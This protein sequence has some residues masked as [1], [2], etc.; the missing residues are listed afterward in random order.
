VL[1]G[2]LSQGDGQRGGPDNLLF[3]VSCSPS[4]CGCPMPA[5]DAVPRALSA[6]LRLT[7]AP[8]ILDV[9]ALSSGLSPRRRA[10]LGQGLVARRVEAIRSSPEYANPRIVGVTSIPKWE[11][12]SLFL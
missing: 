11:L 3:R 9:K 4:L 5:L 12:G 6:V 8:S 7:C 2:S 1:L 10:D